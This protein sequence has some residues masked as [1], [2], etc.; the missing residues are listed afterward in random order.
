MTFVACIYILVWK[1]RTRRPNWPMVLTAVLL[2][3]LATMHLSIDLRRTLDAFYTFRDAPGG[4]VAYFGRINELTH[5]M[6]SA[7]YITHTCVSDAL[8]V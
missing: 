5:V 4:P 2:W 7:V 3:T 6:K 8:V 1:R